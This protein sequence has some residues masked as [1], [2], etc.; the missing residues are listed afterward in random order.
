MSW[1]VEIVKGGE[2][3]VIAKIFLPNQIW[4]VDMATDMQD[5]IKDGYDDIELILR[6]CNGIKILFVKYLF[7]YESHEHVSKVY[8]VA[9]DFAVASQRPIKIED[10]KESDKNE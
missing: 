6:N 7:H 5:Q 10:C 9:G 2:R 3:I 1:K 4:L 8:T